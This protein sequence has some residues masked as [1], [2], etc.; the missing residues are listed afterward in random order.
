MVHS[1]DSFV[2]GITVLTNLLD[3]CQ[4]DVLVDGLE[5]VSLKSILDVKTGKHF[6]KQG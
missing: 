6:I 2:E 5:C 3:D 4:N 1:N